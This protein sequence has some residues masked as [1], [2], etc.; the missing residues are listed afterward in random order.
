MIVLPLVS[1]LQSQKLLVHLWKDPGC[2]PLISQYN[3]AEYNTL[4]VDL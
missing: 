1:N 4:E 2:T 3:I